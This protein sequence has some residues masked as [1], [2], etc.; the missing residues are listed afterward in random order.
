MIIDQE[1]LYLQFDPLSVIVSLNVKSGAVKQ[2]HYADSNT[3]TPNRLLT[4]LYLLPS[5]WTIDPAKIIADGEKIGQLSSGKWYTGSVSPINEVTKKTTDADAGTADYAVGSNYQLVVRKN[6]SHLSPQ[7]LFFV[8]TYFDTRRGMDVT[9]QAA[10]LLST[11]SNAE[12]EAAPVVVLDKPEGYVINPIA[13]LGNTTVKATMFKT[14]NPV[15]A[16]NV[17]YWW[18]TEDDGVEHLIGSTDRDLFYVS[19]QNTDSLVVNTEFIG[20]RLLRCKAQYYTGVAP[21]NPTVSAVT[22]ETKFI[23]RMPASLTHHVERITGSIVQAGDKL[24][25]RRAYAATNGGV[26]ADPGKFFHHRW[27]VNS[28][29]VGAVDVEVAHGISM[30]IPVS[31]AG[32]S[33]AKPA[34]IKLD[35]TEL[36]EYQ[37][38]E[39]PGDD[40]LRDH[41]GNIICGKTTKKG[42]V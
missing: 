22:A 19:G 8:A 15:T 38:I 9:A 12:S 39:L 24:I 32:D 3:Y 29:K 18:Y 40:V 6:I 11:T 21:A 20:T 33:T 2:V 1:P 27:L 4:P 26:V 42:T 35:V 16:G 13:G 14:G 10:E 37:A 36:T 17:K 25:K 28:N 34:T 23:R 41:L 31:Y 5:V 7:Q 30:E